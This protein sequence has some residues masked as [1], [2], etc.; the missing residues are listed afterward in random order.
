MTIGHHFQGQKV[1][2]QP[3]GAGHI[4]AA[5]RTACSDCASRHRLEFNPRVKGKTHA[6]WAHIRIL[7]RIHTACKGKVALAHEIT[8]RISVSVKDLFDSV[9]AQDIISF[10]KE[11]H[12]YST[13]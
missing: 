2:G 13:V 11:S 8:E 10:I 6:Y 1:K 7:N 5:S 9:A 12:F 4:V 3:A